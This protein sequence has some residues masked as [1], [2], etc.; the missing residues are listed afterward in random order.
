MDRERVDPKTLLFVMGYK[1][2][3]HAVFAVIF[4]FGRLR[5]IDTK[6]DA[7]G[8]FFLSYLDMTTVTLLAC[9]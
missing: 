9:E 2:R 1:K 8:I 7:I 4:Y 5:D 3:Q 6:K